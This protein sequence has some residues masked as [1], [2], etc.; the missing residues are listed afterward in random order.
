MK[1]ESRRNLRNGLLFISPWI[2]GFLAFTLYPML[3]ALYYSFTNYG[4]LVKIP[5]WI[6][7]ENYVKI[8]TNDQLFGRV[9]QNTM[10]LVLFGG[11][12]ILALTLTIAILVNNKRLKGTAGFRVIF[13]L[14]TLVPSIVLCLL[15]IWIF[16][17]DSGLINSVLKFFG[18]RGPGWLSSLAWSKPAF[19]IMRLWCSGNLIIIFLGGLQ[20]VPEELYESVEIDGGNF[21]HKTIHVTLPMIR[22]I[23]LFNIITIINGMMQM[24]VEPLVM[25]HRGGGG[26]MDMTYTYALYIY[27]NAFKYS[28]MG[29]AS[30]LA[31]LMLII[32]LTLTFIILR[33]GGFFAD[34][35]AE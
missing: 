10:Y 13:F 28:K 12:L 32:T 2:V 8:L 7:W 34:R 15:W 19:A 20:D 27:N 23:I 1:A 24:F 18:V 17:V 11:V 29:Y 33:T 3:R 16:N 14:P 5:K 4:G 35:E 22:P 30:A 26:P 6:G 31:W 9:M 21:W 25:T